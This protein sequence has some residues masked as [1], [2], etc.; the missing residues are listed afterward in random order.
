MPDDI[1]KLMISEVSIEIL[2]KK[3]FTYNIKPIDKT[4]TFNKALIPLSG[5]YKQFL[6]LGNSDGYGSYTPYGLVSCDFIK[7]IM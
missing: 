5:E 2:L 1:N 7:E 4:K 6:F 3:N